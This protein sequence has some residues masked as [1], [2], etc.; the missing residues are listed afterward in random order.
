LGLNEYN[1]LN[2]PDGTLNQYIQIIDI[3]DAEG[4][5]DYIGVQGHGWESTSRGTIEANLDTLA[6]ETSADLPICLTEY[7]IDIADEGQQAAKYRD[8]IPAFWEHERVEGIT[9][10]GYEEGTTWKAN[11]FILN[12]DGSERE[13][14]TY[15]RENYIETLGKVE[16][17]MWRPANIGDPPPA[18]LAQRTRGQWRIPGD[19]QF[20]QPANSRVSG[21]RGRDGAE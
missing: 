3:L 16:M 10:W 18:K 15:L 7:D 9:L 2:N 20:L 11:T 21:I 8:H 17:N 19:G 6:G 13:A 5:I 4:L 14:L 12:S 1:V